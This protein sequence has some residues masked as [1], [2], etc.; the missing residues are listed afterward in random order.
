MCKDNVTQIYFAD[1]TY[2]VSI[3]YK[4]LDSSIVF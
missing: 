3:S 4:L 2:T 1:I